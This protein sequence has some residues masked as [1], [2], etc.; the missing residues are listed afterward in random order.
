METTYSLQYILFDLDNTVY[1]ASSNVEQAFN[2]RIIEYVSTYLDISLQEADTLRDTGFLRHGTTVS[3]LIAEHGLTDIETYLDWIHMK[4][5]GKYIEPDPA[6]AA[7]LQRIPCGKSILTNSIREHAERVLEAL[8]IR[9]Q[10]EHIFDIRD[11]AYRNKPHPAAYR[12]GLEG[13]GYPAG[14]VLFIDD[15]ISFMQPFLDLG[16]HVLLVDEQQQYSDAT[17]PSIRHIGELEEHLQKHY[18]CG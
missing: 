1:P 11:Y 5:I 9:D 16:G 18:R 6:L 15:N 14:E 10:F 3:W 8:G 17:Y 13:I 7:M 4:D 12:T 2:R